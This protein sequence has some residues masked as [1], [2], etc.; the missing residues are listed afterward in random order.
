M[1]QMKSWSFLLEEGFLIVPDKITAGTISTTQFSKEVT[2]NGTAAAAL[3]VAGTHPMLGER[4]FRIAPGTRVYN[5]DSWDGTTLL[6]KE[7]FQEAS[8]TGSPYEVFR[9]YFR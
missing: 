1:R 3:N 7:E 4:Q 9:C 6:L 8:V 2:P 5:I